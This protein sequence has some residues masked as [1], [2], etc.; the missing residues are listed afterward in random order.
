[1]KNDTRS[2]YATR[3]SI[4]KLLTDNEVAAVSTAESSSTR[5]SDGDEYIDLKKID[6]GV[7]KANSKS[8]S[9]ANFLPKKAVGGET[10]KKI[11]GHLAA[12]QN[13]SNHSGA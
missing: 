7:Q 13:A 2:Q 4:M 1:M 11:V 8:G 12:P 3:E 9:M 5:M 6:Q 10:W